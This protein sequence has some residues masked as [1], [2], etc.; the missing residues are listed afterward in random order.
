MR[1][2]LIGKFGPS[3]VLG[4]T[5]KLRKEKGQKW[6]WWPNA[7][8]RTWYIFN[9][10]T[11]Q[12]LAFQKLQLQGSKLLAHIGYCFSYLLEKQS[13]NS[14]LEGTSL[15][16]WYINIVLVLREFFVSRGNLFSIFSPNPLCI[17]WEV[18]KIIK[19]VPLNK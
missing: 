5:W 11:A 14:N 10:S 2:K 15:H 8:H 18:R 7:V 3:H 19:L 17:F 9:I 1:K 12:G 16:S 13:E 6:G 4:L